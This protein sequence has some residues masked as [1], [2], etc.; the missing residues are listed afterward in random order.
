MRKILMPTDFSDCANNALDY[1]IFLAKKMDAELVLLSAYYIPSS[2]AASIVVNIQEDLR[3]ETQEDLDTLMELKTSKNPWLK[4]SS[5]VDFN[6][7]S[8]FDFT[9]IRLKFY[10]NFFSKEL[11]NF[12]VRLMRPTCNMG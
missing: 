7:P 9:R 4:I 5:I 2:G 6:I 10:Y 12:K 3:K 1:T 8:N 11:C